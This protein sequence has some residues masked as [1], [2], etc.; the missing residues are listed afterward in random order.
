MDA[1]SLAGVPLDGTHGQCLDVSVTQGLDAYL[2][3]GRYTL[4]AWG[5][6]TNGTACWQATFAD[7]QV[8]IGPNAAAAFVVPQVD[9]TG[10]CAP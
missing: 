3:V 1:T 10:F 7:L 8:D 6:E 2:P 5:F 4:V 9:A